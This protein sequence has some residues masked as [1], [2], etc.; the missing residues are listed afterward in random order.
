VF[1]LAGT[2]GNAETVSILYHADVEVIMPAINRFKADNPGVEV[3]IVRP[4][5]SLTDATLLL[6][7]AGTAPDIYVNDAGGAELPFVVERLALPLDEY[8]ERDFEYF[9]NWYP[10]I[11]EG[12]TYFGKRYGVPNVDFGAY[13][14][15]INMDMLSESGVGVPSQDWTFDDFLTIAQKVSS[16]TDGDGVRD[17]W[18]YS[19]ESFHGWKPWVINGGGSLFA[20]SN[21]RNITFDSRETINALQWLQDLRFN[22]GVI[23]IRADSGLYTAQAFAQNRIAMM[24]SNAADGLAAARSG[25]RQADVLLPPRGPGGRSLMVTYWGWMISSHSP[26]PD[27]AWEL[28]KYL[29]S[30]DQQRAVL[31]ARSINVQSANVMRERF[32]LGVEDVPHFRETFLEFYRYPLFMAIPVMSP[33]AH[34]IITQTVQSILNGEKSAQVAVSEV[35]DQIRA[36]SDEFWRRV[37]QMTW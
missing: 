15:W 35:G 19:W 2:L 36:V 20:P 16:D 18:G 34:N 17:R 7:A 22:Y 14:L 29:V 21:P 12:V 25:E 27:L 32:G 28:I 37:D 31:N 13:A 26:H 3:E 1:I 4:A 11:W 6:H 10:G 24:L 9:K 5:G 33:E 23:G 8:Y 30:E